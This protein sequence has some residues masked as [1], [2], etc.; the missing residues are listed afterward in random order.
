MAVR[1]YRDENLP[2]LEIKSCDG[3]IHSSRR[4]A[5]EEFSVG[6]V[7][8]GASRVGGAGR[9]YRVGPGSFILIPPRTIHDCNPED[10][11]HWRFNMLYMKREWVVSLLDE[12]ESDLGIAVKTLPLPD[13]QRA[14]QFIAALE[15]DLP[16]L[17]KETR[18]IVELGY[19]FDFE[20]YFQ[21][22][23]SQSGG[24]L[25]TVRR[26]EEYLRANF[27]EKISLDQLAAEAGLSKY[28][29]VRLF[30]KTLQTSPHAY[31]TMLRI[32]FAKEELRRRR[33][34]S[35]TAIAQEAGF[36]DQSHFVKAFKQYSGT[37]PI[38]YRRAMGSRVQR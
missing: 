6:L 26:A 31:Q 12:A 7:V 15:T 35:I 2:F 14:R 37:T 38:G 13:Y 34:A 30:E 3:G 28:H 1:F 17:E 33:A 8:H 19:F 11:D 18:L 5:H 23:A 20:S 27:R 10:P 29:L 21:I 32:N 24:D 22:P 9:E 4:H 36:Y 25:R 16:A